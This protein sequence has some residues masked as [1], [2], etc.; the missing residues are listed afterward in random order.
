MEGPSP[1]WHL[2]IGDFFFFFYYT[3]G[4]SRIK[5]G[6]KGERQSQRSDVGA[7][8]FSTNSTRCSIILQL[9]SGTDPEPRSFP[10]SLRSPL[11]Q[12]LS[13]TSILGGGGWVVLIDH[14]RLQFSYTFNFPVHM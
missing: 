10:P 2:V 12:P 9:D 3:T 1:H 5:L 13:H 8:I 7:C 6:G 4:I 11:P 14:G